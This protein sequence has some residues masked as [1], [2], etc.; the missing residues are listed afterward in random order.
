MWKP[1]AVEGNAQSRK[2][3]LIIWISAKKNT[4][5]TRNETKECLNRGQIDN[6]VKSLVVGPRP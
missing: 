6:W 5:E 3:M 4:E 2:L 1:I